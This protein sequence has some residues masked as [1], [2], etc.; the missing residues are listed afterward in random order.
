[1][2]NSPPLPGGAVV[3]ETYLPE[4]GPAL[5]HGYHRT[6]D[7]MELSD[8][9][10]FLRDRAGDQINV[11]GRKIFPETIERL[12]LAHPQ[13]L[14]CLGFG[15]P[16]ADA[17]RTDSI[18]AGVAATLSGPVSFP[19]PPRPILQTPRQIINERPPAFRF[20]GRVA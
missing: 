18:V 7:L 10:V 4:P 1:L 14:E 16:S 15:V 8:G 13:V 2:I 9:L 19:T 11:A 20:H 17:E 6:N 5:A 3:A 12:R